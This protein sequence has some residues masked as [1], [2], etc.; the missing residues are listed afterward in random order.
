MTINYKGER[1]T[2]VSLRRGLKKKYTR[3]QN[4]MA[5]KVKGCSAEKIEIYKK[6]E[7]IRVLCRLTP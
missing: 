7:K 5:A 2:K 4:K 1:E 6:G 3:K